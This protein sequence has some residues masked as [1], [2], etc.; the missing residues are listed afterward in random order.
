MLASITPLGERGRHANWWITASAFLLASSAAGA[1]L[2]GA[3]GAL[4]SFAL[5]GSFGARARLLA[6]G[7]AVLGALL[8]DVYARRVPGPRRQVDERWLHAYR[9]WVYGAGYGAQLGLGVS[10]VVSSAAMYASFLAALLSGDP[11]RG[12]TILGCFGALRGVTLFLGIGVRDPE[13]L[14]SFHARLTRWRAPTARLAAISLG[15]VSV[16]SVIGAAT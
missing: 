12:A 11:G 10:T 16:L 1:V 5:P 9:G 14:V 6:L 3:L 4:G 2:G 7:V 8:V 15:A 13:R